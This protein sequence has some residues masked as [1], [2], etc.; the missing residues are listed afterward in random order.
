MPGL[1]WVNAWIAA[2]LKVSWNVDPDP[3]IVPLLLEPPP[4]VPEELVLLLE[5][6]QAA[7]TSASATSAI[8]RARATRVA[9]GCDQNE[10]PSELSGASVSEH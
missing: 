7:R 6:P 4:V 9:K 3:L 8:D 2:W 5:L 10:A 1:A